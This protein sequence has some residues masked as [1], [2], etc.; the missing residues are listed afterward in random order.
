M[1]RVPEE[2]LER[3]M[4]ITIDVN[5]VVEGLLKGKQSQYLTN[6]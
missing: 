1:H 4:Q 6:D 5:P 2:H 3:G